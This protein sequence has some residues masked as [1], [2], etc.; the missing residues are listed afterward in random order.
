MVHTSLSSSTGPSIYWAYIYVELE[1]GVTCADSRRCSSHVNTHSF[2]LCLYLHTYGNRNNIRWRYNIGCVFPNQNYT[3]DYMADQDIRKYKWIDLLR[4]TSR[5]HYL[6]VLLQVTVIWRS[7]SKNVKLIFAT[8][9]MS[10][11]C[12]CLFVC[13]YLLFCLFVCGLVGRCW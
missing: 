3:L 5:E 11:Y 7:H 8:F 9:T 2:M 4:S 12:Y 6:S 13:F 10:C 1:G